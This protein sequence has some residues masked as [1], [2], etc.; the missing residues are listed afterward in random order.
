[1]QDIRHHF[2]Q[3]VRELRLRSGMSQETLAHRAGLDRTYI[4]DVERG[5]RNVSL[6]N[7]EKIA[8]ALTVSIEYMFSGERFSATPTYLQ[9]DFA[10]PI[11]ERFKYHLDPETRV[12]A[13]TVK[14][15]LTP[16]DVAYM[17]RMLIGLCT[18]F[19]RGEIS[20]LVDHRFM[21]AADRE[22][23]V[24]SPE[25]AEKAVE[26]QKKLLGYSKKVVVLCNSQFMVQNLNHVTAIS[27][28]YDKSFQLFGKDRDMVQQA[29]ELLGI[30]GNDLIKEKKE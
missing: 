19:D 15:L 8:A 7:I 5:A 27:G 26:F 20:L 29:Y 24:Y 22:P 30:N 16:Q 11:Q 2:G 1:M 12:L 14:G 23:A 6:V 3:R 4:T 28:I 17:D 25:V 10:E 13:F 9:K 21:L 18:G